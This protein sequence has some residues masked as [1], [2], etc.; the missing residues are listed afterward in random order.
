MLCIKNSYG[1]E[2]F[3]KIPP[4]FAAASITISGLWFENNSKTSL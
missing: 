1:K 2:L 4:T 3:A